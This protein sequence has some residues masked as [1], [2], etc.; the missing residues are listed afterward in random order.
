MYGTKIKKFYSYI[1]SD[2]T[3]DV[4]EDFYLIDYDNDIFEMKK[5]KKDDLLVNFYDNLIHEDMALSEKY[6]LNEK[7]NPIFEIAKAD[8]YALYDVI[9]ELDISDKK[10]VIKAVEEGLFDNKF[11]FEEV[12]KVVVHYGNK[13]ETFHYEVTTENYSVVGENHESKK[14]MELLKKS[15]FIK[16]ITGG[17]GEFERKGAGDKWCISVIDKL[18]GK[19]CIYNWNKDVILEHLIN[20][21]PK[22]M[23]MIERDNNK[24]VENEIDK[25]KEICII[26]SDIENEPEQVKKELPDEE[27][28]TNNKANNNGF[29]F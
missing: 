6:I 28:E 21:F 26:P 24:S 20:E 7:N 1:I 13:V 10:S 17:S 22:E 16:G 27:K 14:Y 4:E 3:K 12:F 29:E 8:M 11:E 15:E 2:K 23:E 25:P 9:Q 19:P 5:C 18:N